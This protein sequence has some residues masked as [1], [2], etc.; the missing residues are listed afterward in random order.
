MLAKV[1]KWGNSQGLRLA[2]HL[3]DDA[4]ISVGDEVEVFVQ[5]EQIRIKKIS[6]PKFD[7]AEMVSR[8]PA[9]YKAN[10]ESFG[11]PVGKEEW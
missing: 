1:Q 10:E 5:Q 8:M 7:L 4:R 6:K 11:K 3:L 2:K 9:S